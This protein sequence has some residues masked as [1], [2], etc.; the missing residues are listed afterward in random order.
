MKFDI[1]IG[2]PPYQENDNGQRDD[3][4]VNASASPLYHLFTN[5]AIKISQNQS[6]IIPARWTTGAGKGLSEFSKNMINDQHIKHFTMFKKSDEVFPNTDI[7]G[8]IAYF[9]READYQG[10]AEI[11][12]V[13]GQERERYTEYL[14]SANTGIFIP[15]KELIEILKKV[16]V[17][18]PE[19]RH[20]ENMQKIVSVL[21]P[22]G[23]RTDFF[24]NPQK[25]GKPEVF[26]DAKS[27]GDNPI[28]IFGLIK[29]KRTTRYVPNDYPIDVGTDSI[30]TFKIFAPYACGAGALGE[31]G[32][33][34]MLGKPML[35]KPMQIATETFLRIGN[36]KTQFEAEALIKYYKSKF[37]RVMVGILKTTQ[38]STT[39]YG[40]VP[41][42]DFTPNS[43]I[44]WSQPI[45]DIDQQLY[46]KYGL[47]D[48]EIDFIETK[49]KAMD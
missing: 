40:Y 4:S 47:S 13:N 32:A 31:A 46:R 38:H 22:Y 41:L 16:E 12:I 15:F 8:G 30:Q 48:A 35:G 23:L 37:F 6:L 43:D 9:V 36:F 5:L 26:A 42:Q 17:K 25:Y 39:T 21:K 18:T 14:N 3:G 2:N 19:L 1:V 10:P 7:K 44:D 11:T 49:V 34:P 20:G 45:P 29:G 27:A 28:E 24:S 33:T